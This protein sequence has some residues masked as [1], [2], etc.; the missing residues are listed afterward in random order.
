[1]RISTNGFYKIKNILVYQ[2]SLRPRMRDIKNKKRLGKFKCEVLSLIITLYVALNPKCYSY[3]YQLPAEFNRVQK[4][5]GYGEFIDLD[6]EAF[7]KYYK[8]IKMN[9]MIYTI[10]QQIKKY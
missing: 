4:E 10:K 2:I 1:M 3:E 9:M 6:P 7:S 5:R 8:K